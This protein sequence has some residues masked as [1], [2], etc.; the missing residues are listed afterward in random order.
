VQPRVY[1]RSYGYYGARPY[2]FRPRTRLAFGIYLG[3]GV[4]YAYTYAY[5]VPVYGYG[6][7]AA[8]VYIGPDSTL[9]GGVTLEI[10]PENAEV[11]VDGQDVGTVADFDG[12]NGPLNLT[13]GQHH[14]EL[15]APGYVPLA[16]DV[17]VV[18]GQLIPY[19]GD[20]QPY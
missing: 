20:M 15:S 17:N 18:P 14:I 13:A 9:Y 5:P 2:I 4:P 8:P 1:A 10:S 6:A 16:M 3:Y 19:R 7:P 11:F 12:T